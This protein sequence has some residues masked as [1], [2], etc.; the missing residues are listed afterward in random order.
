[1]VIYNREE[2]LACIGDQPPQ[3]PKGHVFGK[4]GDGSIRA[5]YVFDR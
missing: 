4:N 3:L 1:M 2:G 5:I